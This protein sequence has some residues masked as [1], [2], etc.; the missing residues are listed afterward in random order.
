MERNIEVY[1]NK[2]VKYNIN[3]FFEEMK[4][5][6]DKTVENEYLLIKIKDYV[7]LREKGYN[8]SKKKEVL[9]DPGV[10]E[11]K[12]SN[13][14]SWEDSIN[15]S[16]FLDSLPENH[17]FSWDYPC[18]MNPQYQD[19]FLEKTWE[20][21]QKYYYHPNYIITVQSKFNNY[22]NFVEWFDKYNALNIKSGIMGL[23]NMCRFRTLNQY[24]KHSLDY[25]FSHC[26]HQRIHIYGLCL[27]AIPYA[28]NLANKFNIE[29]SVD[30]T[31]WTRSVSSN[32]RKKY[33]NLAGCR[34]NNRQDYFNEYL[35]EIKKRGV[36]I[37]NDITN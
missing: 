36:Q 28:Y 1:K 15:I 23:G 20:N 22:W 6:T 25:A 21:T 8:F 17:Y 11:L 14:Y 29:L 3:Y 13:E 4:F 5:F 34:K 9:I 12:K 26:N 27:K 24:F 16:E 32:L 33:N 19:L 37:E 35:K 18:D 2:T 30:S 10:Y 7:R 31:K